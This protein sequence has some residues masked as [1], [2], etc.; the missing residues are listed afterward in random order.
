EKEHVII[1]EN[2][3]LF[4]IDIVKGQKTGFFLDQRDNRYL[5]GTYYKDKTVLNTFCYSGGFS[6]SALNAG[7]K[8]VDSVDVSANAIDLTHRNVV[9]NS[10]V[11]VHHKAYV[12]DVMKFLKK[13]EVP[14]YDIV[15]LDPPA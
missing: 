2:D 10:I 12:D 15:V 6:L 8:R 7:A 3:I 4:H 5:L 1:R 9:L 14:Q 11:E 13:E